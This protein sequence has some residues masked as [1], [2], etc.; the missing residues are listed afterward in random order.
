MQVEHF[1][2]RLES[3]I[4]YMAKKVAI[5]EEKSNNVFVGGNLCGKGLRHGRLSVWVG[6]EICKE[7]GWEADTTVRV[8]YDKEK[9]CFLIF[10]K[11]KSIE[12]Y[13]VRPGKYARQINFAFPINKNF[14]R[15]KVKFEAKNGELIIYAKEALQKGVVGNES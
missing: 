10:P 6:L 5:V 15:E 2:G 11:D 3:I 9:G 12:S 8:F 4:P 13:D 14:K 1:E 7:L